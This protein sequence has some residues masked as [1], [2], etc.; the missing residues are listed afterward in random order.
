MQKNSKAASL[1]HLKYHHFY[2]FES[3]S[4]FIWEI[5]IR[6]KMQTKSKTANH[7]S[8]STLQEVRP[9]QYC[10]QTNLI[11]PCH[12]G[13]IGLNFGIPSPTKFANFF[14]FFWKFSH[15]SWRTDYLK[16]FFW[17]ASSCI[18]KRGM[19][20]NFWEFWNA[21]TITSSS[22]KQ[23]LQFRVTSNTITHPRYPPWQWMRG[24]HIKQGRLLFKSERNSIRYLQI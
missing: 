11:E 7:C 13:K 8:I 15:K 1:N 10:F 2:Y 18:K 21:H 4:N 16:Q 12:V 24:S 17:E 19:Q 9:K 20:P 3:E 14:S 5:W 23:D 22:K 6:V